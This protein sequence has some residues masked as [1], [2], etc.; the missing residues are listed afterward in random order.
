MWKGR[1]NPTYLFTLKP[2]N[3][4]NDPN[5]LLLESKYLYE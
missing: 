4:V 5:E 2:K 3:R 1:P